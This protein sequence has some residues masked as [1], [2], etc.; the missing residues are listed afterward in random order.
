MTPH[1]RRRAVAGHFRDAVPRPRRA[2]AGSPPASRTPERCLVLG[3]AA[4]DQ[5]RAG[6]SSTAPASTRRS[7]RAS[8]RPDGAAHRRRA[9]QRAGPRQRRAPR[10]H[11][12]GHHRRPR[13][14]RPRARRQVGRRPREPAPAPVRGRRL[15]RRVR[16]RRR[17]D[18]ARRPPLRPHAQLA[19]PQ[20]RLRPR[21]RHADAARSSRPIMAAVALAIRLDGRGP[22]LFRQTRV[23]RDGERFEI[24]KFRTMVPD[25]EA[26]KG[27]LAHLNE[28]AGPVQDR[29]RP[30]DHPRRPASCAARRSTSCRSCSTSGAAR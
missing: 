4:G 3:D 18:D 5:H 13:H 6:A 23:G 7:S 30:A 29:R 10:D 15:L 22:V 17:P 12:P 14:A 2:R 27:N 11:R 28:T 21:R 16:P 8:A 24:F 20:A 9:L 1:A 25:A 26:L 19:R